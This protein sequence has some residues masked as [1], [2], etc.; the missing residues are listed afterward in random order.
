MLSRP[1]ILATVPLLSLLHTTIAVPEPGT[2]GFQFHKRTVSGEQALGLR[3]RQSGTV[4]SGLDNEL[5][6]YLINVTVGTPGQD[7]SLQLDTGSSDIWFPTNNAN[8]CRESADNCPVGTYDVQASSTYKDPQLPEFQIEY[9]DGTQITGSYISDTLSLGNT[10][11]TNMTMAAATNLNSLGVGIMGVG[12]KADESGAT[13]AQGS[14]GFTYP[15]IIDVLQS[16]GFIKSRVYSLWLDDLESNTGSILFGGVDSDKYTGSLVALPIQLDSQSN[17]IT[18]FTVAWTGLQV[19]GSGNNLDAS[20]SSPAPAILDS[21]TTDTLLPDSI[22]EQIFNG[23]GVTTTEKFGNVVPCELANDDLTFT[24]TF[25]GDGGPSIQVPLSEFVVPLQTS[26]GQSPKFRDGKDACQFAIEAAGSAPILFG[27]SFLRSAYVVY[28]LENQQVALAQLNSKAQQGSGN[29]QVVGS[30]SAIPGVSS[31]ATAASVAQTIT[32]IP[33]ESQEATATGDIQSGQQ[34]SRSAT[35]KFSATESS[36][37][38]S[39]TSSGAASGNVQAR[40]IRWQG[41]ASCAVVVLGMVF[42]GG[43]LIL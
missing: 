20:P 16:E 2:I 28:D 27:D 8:V 6:L 29:V 17:S 9:V 5:S 15:N 31:T 21:G 10:Q 38:S 35:F 40:P 19:N 3:R 24:F 41:L 42:G 4:L 37:G 23:V 34:T 7:F 22:A 14:Q 12:F 32:G 18:S 39:S 1:S 13:G 33:R 26:D 30:S 36:S 43:L 11:L 25:G